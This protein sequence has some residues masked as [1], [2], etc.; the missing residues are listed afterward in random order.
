MIKKLLLL[1]L[2]LLPLA[3]LA[4]EATLAKPLKEKI[5]TYS[6]TNNNAGI[7]VLTGKNDSIST[8]AVGYADAGEKTPVTNDHLFEIGSASKIFTA[9]AIF[10]LIEENKLSLHTTLNTL[11]P[12]GEIK[13][14]ANYEGQNYWD[15]VTVEMLLNHTSGFIDYLNAYGSDEEA[16]KAFSREKEYTFDELI[17]LSASHGDANFV[18]G[19]R[20]KYSNTNYI[21]LGDIISKVSEMHWKTYI[22]RNILEK[23]G[24][25]NTFFGSEIS[26]ENHQ[27]LMTGYYGNKITQI[28]YSLAGSAGEIISNLYDLHKFLLFWSEGKFYKNPNTFQQQLSTGVHNMSPK[29]NLVKY[30]LGTMMVGEMVGHGGQTFGFQSYLAI[31]PRTHDVCVIGI[32]NAAVSSISL[33]VNLMEM[34]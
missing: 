24:L 20:F 9:I 10:Q 28:P 16:L 19:S 15:Q 31:N 21:I 33:L 17:C 4:Q 32:N 23:A 29:S 11:Y 2:G 18:P 26:P 8:Y 5:V 7:L 22:Q 34:N 6:S 1:A 3:T 27:R 14:L 13:A 30:A 25:K 12:G